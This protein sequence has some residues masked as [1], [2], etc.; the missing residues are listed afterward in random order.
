MKPTW[1]FIK[2]FLYAEYIDLRSWGFDLNS[3]QAFK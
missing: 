1:L 3:V 2:D